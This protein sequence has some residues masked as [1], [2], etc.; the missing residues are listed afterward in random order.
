MGKAGINILTVFLCAMAFAQPQPQ[1]LVDT[2]AMTIG[3][4]IHY[5]LRIQTDSTA[6]VAFPKGQSFLPFEIIDTTKINRTFVGDKTDWSRVYTLIHFDSGTYH[7]P[8]QKVWVDGIAFSTDSLK[9]Q[10]H[11][12]EVDT[13]KQP[14]FPIKP[15]IEIEKN[16]AGWWHPY[17]ILFLLLGALVA[18]YFLFVKARDKIRE[19]RKALPPFERALQALQALETDHLL[20]Q[21]DYKKYY[22]T[23]TD[24]VRNYLEDDAHVDAMESTSSQ[25]IAKLELLRDAGNLDLGKE[26]I[27]NL[28]S[29]LETADLVKF[30]KAA[31]GTHHAVADRTAIESVV[32]QTKEALPEPTEEE[33]LQDEAY[34]KAM[35]KQQRLRQFKRI[36]W[37][38]AAVVLVGFGTSVA[39]Y[40]FQSVKDRI[41]GHPTLA[42]TEASW[43]TSVYGA[44]PVRMSTP[45]VLTRIPSGGS[46]V[47]QFGMGSLEDSFQFLLR[48]EQFMNPEG[49]EVDIN[50]RAATLLRQLEEMGATNIFQKDESYQTPM[51]VQ[52][53][54]L[55]GS[56]DWKHEN[57]T[58]RKE[59]Q[60]LY[61]AENKGLQQLRI[62]YDRGDPYVSTVVAR[63]LN[64]IDFNTN[65]Q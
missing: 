55:S 47:Q 11:N 20:E 63:I 62:I 39:L 10:V 27:D 5:E 15:I 53:V 45:E 24:I 16:T 12:V 64:S 14:L 1:A 9:I 36:G 31:P 56:F 4:D 35:R 8:Q 49:T 37:I 21:E 50:E 13:L 19:K 17:A 2:T 26:T 59:Y 42:L 22:S 29:V 52:G 54:A 28:Q 60:V 25:L 48:I 7:I 61:F 51:G 30:A 44:T 3:E 46:T 23:L 38:G 58:I 34:R 32:K 65:V 57:E 40:G 33:R 41:F 6:R 18:S 43:I